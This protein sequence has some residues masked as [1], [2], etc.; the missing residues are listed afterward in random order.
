MLLGSMGG[1]NN[2]V[3]DNIDDNHEIEVST[4]ILFYCFFL[5]CSKP[6]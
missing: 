6:V 4:I 2:K 3:T 1:F 5:K